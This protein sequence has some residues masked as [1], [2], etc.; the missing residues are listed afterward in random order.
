MKKWKIDCFKLLNQFFQFCV[1]AQKYVQ[2]N[3]RSKKSI[4]FTKSISK[5]ISHKQKCPANLWHSFLKIYKRFFWRFNFSNTK[6]VFKK[7]DKNFL[8][9]LKSNL[10]V[11]FNKT[12]IIKSNN[13]KNVLVTIWLFYHL[14]NMFLVFSVS[15]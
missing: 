3:F 11:L 2:I 1:K 13:K 5:K 9:N 8:K 6:I 14:M 7:I 4:N 10:L 12:T 15:I